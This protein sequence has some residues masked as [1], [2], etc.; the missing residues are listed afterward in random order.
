MSNLATPTG[1]G[2]TTPPPPPA[3]PNLVSL[4]INGKKITVPKGTLLVEAEIG[5][6]HV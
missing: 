4:T 5:R 6:A 3:N 2:P 1:T